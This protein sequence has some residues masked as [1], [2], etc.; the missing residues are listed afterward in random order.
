M[1]TSV[2]AAAVVSKCL[3]VNEAKQSEKQSMECTKDNVSESSSDS[4][5]S[6][7]GSSSS[8]CSSDSS[9]TSASSSSSDFSEESSDKISADDNNAL[10][11]GGVTTA[12]SILLV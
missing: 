4:R 7:S 8:S 6:G 2:M 1:A 10:G 9:N 5:G 12:M 11:A 3:V